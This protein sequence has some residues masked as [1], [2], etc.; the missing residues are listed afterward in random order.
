MK[1]CLKAKYNVN[2]LTT[3][4]LIFTLSLL[5]PTDTLNVFH[6]ALGSKATVIFHMNG[7]ILLR[8]SH[9]TQ[10]YSASDQ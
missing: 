1:F 8:F 2:Y 9:M 3:P 5:S 7:F 10:R 6:H 4:F